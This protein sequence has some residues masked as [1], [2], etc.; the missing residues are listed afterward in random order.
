M[1]I[2]RANYIRQKQDEYAE[3]FGAEWDALATAEAEEEE[4][5]HEAERKAREEEEKAREERERPA[6]EAAEREAREAQALEEARIQAQVEADLQ[7]KVK[8]RDDIE[9]ASNTPA[10]RALMIKALER[11]G[12]I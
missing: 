2:S 7:E 6:R 10:L 5:I 3:V 8:L 1:Q 11:L 4:R 9:K 12:A